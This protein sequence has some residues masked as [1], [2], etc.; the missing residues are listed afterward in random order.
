MPYAQPHR[1]SETISCSSTEKSHVRWNAHTKGRGRKETL[2]EGSERLVSD[3]F[4]SWAFGSTHLVLT[5]NTNGCIFSGL[6][7]LRAVRTGQ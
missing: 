5:H 2:K 6:G 3:T 4:R 7:V 1:G